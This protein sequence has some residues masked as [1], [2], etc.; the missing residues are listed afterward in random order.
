MPR[1]KLENPFP[2]FAE[3]TAA[4]ARIYELKVEQRTRQEGKRLT[5]FAVSLLLANAALVLSLFWLTQNLHEEG[6]SAGSIMLGSFLILG[7]LS[8]TSAMLGLKL[9]K[10][11]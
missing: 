5:L 2:F 11:V 4:A 9:R 7:S 6:W 8:A 3:A 1:P 10:K